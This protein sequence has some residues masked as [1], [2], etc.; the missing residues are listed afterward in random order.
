MVGD[1]KVQAPPEVT[2]CDQGDKQDPEDSLALLHADLRIRRPV[3]TP[4]AKAPSG[5]KCS[6]HKALAL[7]AL[8]LSLL[9]NED[10]E[11]SLCCSG[12]AVVVVLQERSGCNVSG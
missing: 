2:S 5:S 12:A 4:A 3:V 6:V 9:L 7:S 1:S 10:L 11:N 8:A